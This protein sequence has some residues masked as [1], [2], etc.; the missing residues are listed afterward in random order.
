MGDDL[1]DEREVLVLG[2]GERLQLP[3]AAHLVHM[4]LID[5]AVRHA[6]GNVHD[7]LAHRGRV[8]AAVPLLT[9]IPQLGDL[10]RLGGDDRFRD[11]NETIVLQLVLRDL[12]QRNDALVMR[13][14]H[15]DVGEVEL[16][17]RHGRPHHV[18][19]P[20]GGG[21]AR[22]GWRGGAMVHI[23]TALGGE[24][25]GR[26]NEGGRAEERRD[27]GATSGHDVIGPSETDREM[28]G[29]DAV[30]R[31]CDQFRKTCRRARRTVASGGGGSG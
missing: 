31:L 13:D 12:G 27:E 29:R 30:T 1:V 6:H 4:S 22:G 14:H 8:R 16:H 25:G 17:H 10:G 21:G 5:A 20:G 9:E 23:V 7:L 28:T 3:L 11:A 2:S 24:P 19:V 15:V 26:D 18:A